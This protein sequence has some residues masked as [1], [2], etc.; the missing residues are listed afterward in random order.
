MVII[1]EEVKVA[2]EKTMPYCIATS[3][4]NGVANIVYVTFL[5]YFDESTVVI[6][7]NKFAKTFDNLKENGNISFVVMDSDTKKA[8]QLKGKVEYYTEGEK[9]QFVSDWV[10]SKRP[11]I[12]TKGAVYLKIEEIYFGSEKIA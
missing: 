4:S 11:D 7:D 2:I 3:D 6:A 12:N 5:K 10:H 9:Y 1:P 8:F